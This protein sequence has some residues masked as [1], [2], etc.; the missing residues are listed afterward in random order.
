MSRHLRLNL[1]ALLCAAPLCAA[2]PAGLLP[3]ADHRP[4]VPQPL[5]G[6]RYTAHEALLAYVRALATAAPDRVR[7]STLNISEE[8]REQPFLVISSPENL[9]RLDEL[10]A[11]QAKLADPRI[12]TEAEARR[13][14]ET[15]PVFVWLG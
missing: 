2:L 4:D 1:P 8:G 9:R 11:L 13:I 14:A 5:L 6:Q 3:A 10:K 12:C 15:S 7:L